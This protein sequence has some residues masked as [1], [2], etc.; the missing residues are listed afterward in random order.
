MVSA[1]FLDVLSNRKQVWLAIGLAAGLT[2]IA[3]RARD[4]T[5]RQGA[6]LEGTIAPALVNSST[7]MLAQSEGMVDRRATG[8]PAD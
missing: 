3:R 5:N 8:G 6:S 1:L 7:P 4:T 2:Y